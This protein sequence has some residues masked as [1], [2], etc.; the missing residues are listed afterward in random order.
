[1]K[2]VQLEIVLGTIFVFL[3]G[4]LLVVMGIEEPARLARFEGMQLAEKIE[5]GASVYEVN[6]TGCHGTRAQGVEGKAPC[7]R[8]RELFAPIAI[9]VDGEIYQV[10]SDT[11]VASD[12]IEGR[13]VR[14]EYELEDE[15]RIATLIEVTDASSSADSGVV[16]G[17]VDHYK[18]RIGELG[19]EA[20][21][22]DYIVSVV[23]TGR[24][25]S[26]RPQY[27]GGGSPAMPTWAE[28]YGGPLRVDQVAAVSAF[29]FNFETWALNPEMIPEPLIVE[30]DSSDPALR[31]RAVFAQLSCA[32][33][34]T[35]EGVTAGVGGP[36]LDGVASR[37]AAMGAGLSAEEYI[38][39]SILDPS[40]FV[41][42]GFVDGLMPATFGESL[43]PEQLEDL[44]AFL[45]SL[46]E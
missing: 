21:L 33:C 19:W 1:M 5:F 42:E 22:E 45:L 4:V 3:S 29:I 11:Q 44:I 41:V 36:A 14:I 10:N 35:V 34:H 40:A 31:G 27:F 43:T 28:R 30:I 46:E 8:C 2:R 25:V 26:T 38:R 12:V 9:T 24:Q 6:C 7:L 16:V 18:D 20:S 15:V 37:A 13:V 39:Q 17:I 23:S 32:A